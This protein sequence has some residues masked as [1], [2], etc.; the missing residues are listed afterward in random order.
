[1]I[2][3][4]P[5][6]FSNMEVWKR[7]RGKMIFKDE[8][9][10]SKYQS[11]LVR[12]LKTFGDA[13][14]MMLTTSGST[15][16]VPKNYP[17]PKK[18]FK[19][20]NNHHMWRIFESNGIKEGN[21]VRIFQTN[22][23]ATNSLVGPIKSSCMGLQNDTWD[24]IY[25]PSATNKSFWAPIL[26]RIGE[27]RPVFVYTSPSSFV[28]MREYLDRPFECPVIFSCETLTDAVR[29]E[30]LLF[31]DR[32]IDKM[33]DWTTGLGFFE[34]QLGIKHIYDELCA[35]RQSEDGRLWCL[36]FFNHCDRSEKLSDDMATIRRA[37]CGCGVYGNII[38]IFEGKNFECL[39]SVAGK[40][41]S[42]NYVSNHL[43]GLSRQGIIVLNYQI[44]QDDKKNVSIK[45]SEKIDDEKAFI[46][47]ATISQILMDG[48]GVSR[49]LNEGSEICTSNEKITI[50]IE[51]SDPILNG[52]KKISLRS[53][54]IS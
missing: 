54:A 13:K 28:A 53:K 39:V 11:L 14:P 6:I 2:K 1:M 10:F 4:N 5:N 26:S 43:L 23:S 50:S 51:K 17:F 8:I 7:I 31:F 48:K 38:D 16:N 33:R 49:I 29:M 35:V 52:N 32:A 22:S 12:S 20:V 34:C 3:H 46:L 25:N 19:M 44:V 27:L 45:T 37:T 41:Y 9:Q 30:S 36:D 21:A 40:R 24:M 47:G 15:S 18:L 42:A